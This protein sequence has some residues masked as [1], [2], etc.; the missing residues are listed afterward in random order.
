MTNSRVGRPMRTD[1]CGVVCYYYTLF[2]RI[3]TSGSEYWAYWRCDSV[4]R[5]CTTFA[6]NYCSVAA[7]TGD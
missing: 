3:T 1:S 6:E 7:K 5:K 4:G 2:N